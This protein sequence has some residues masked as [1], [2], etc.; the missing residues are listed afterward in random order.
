MKERHANWTVGKIQKLF[1]ENKLDLE[2]P[3]QRKEIWTDIAKSTFLSKA[4]SGRRL[5]LL[6]VREGKAFEVLDGKQRLSSLIRFMRN[7]FPLKL[8]QTDP[9]LS[10]DGFFFQD[11]P[12]P[13]KKAMMESAFDVYVYS[14]MS[15]EDVR[16][17]FISVNSGQPVNSTEKN[18]AKLSKYALQKINTITELSFFYKKINLSKASKARYKDQEILFQTLVLLNDPTSGTGTKDINKFLD[19][20]EENFDFFHTLNELTELTIEFGK[21]FDRPAPFLKKINVAII[22]ALTLRFVKMEIPVKVI[23]DALYDFFEN[24]PEEFKLA[25][26]DGSATKDKVQ[27]RLSILEKWLDFVIRRDYG[28]VIKSASRVS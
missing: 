20:L 7:E 28:N 9:N 21:V 1:L 26:Q 17:E 8:D 3:F 15:E 5:G 16:R 18:R 22:Y 2:I 12:D 11:L 24:V 14:E 19:G 10:F 13:V 23:V 6:Q 27:K 25:S 4:L